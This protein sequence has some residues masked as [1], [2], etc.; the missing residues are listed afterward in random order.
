MNSESKEAAVVMNHLHNV[1]EHVSAKYLGLNW[2]ISVRLPRIMKNYK[3]LSLISLRLYSYAT[4]AFWL[5]L[6]NKR[7]KIALTRLRCFN[8]LSTYTLTDLISLT[9][10]ARVYSRGWWDFRPSFLIVISDSNQRVGMRITW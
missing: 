7:R 1:E 9:S 2:H 8:C 6:N 3:P 5:L 4:V 10:R